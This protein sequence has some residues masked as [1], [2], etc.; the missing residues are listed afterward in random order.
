M[1]TSDDPIECP[2]CGARHSDACFTASG[3]DH[4]ARVR[5]IT[6]RATPAD[7]RALE[8]RRGEVA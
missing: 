3:R 6:G 2:S 8:R 1:T 5:V 4:A 7:E